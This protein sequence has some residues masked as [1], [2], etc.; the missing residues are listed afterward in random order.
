MSD[1]FFTVNV[2]NNLNTKKMKEKET[3][4]NQGDESEDKYTED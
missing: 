1:V 4:L 3:Y 2:S